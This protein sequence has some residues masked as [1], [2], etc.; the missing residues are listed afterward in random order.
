VSAGAISDYA[1][2]NGGMELPPGLGGGQGRPG[3]A[4][5]ARSQ[6]PPTKMADGNPAIR[7]GGQEQHETLFK[8][9]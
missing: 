9:C 4:A 5:Q 7:P 8:Y 2:S 3:V 6:A 1:T